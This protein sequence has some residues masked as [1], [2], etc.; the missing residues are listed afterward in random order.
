M[1][2]A[3]PSTVLVKSCLDLLRLRGIFAFRVNTTGVYDTARK[4]FR[5]FQ[6]TKGVSDIVAVVPRTGRIIA[7][8][9]KH[10]TGRLSPDQR[11]FLD[12]VTSA[13]GL[14]LVIRD[15]LDLDRALTAEGIA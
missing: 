6:G 3:N 10:G 1:K 4:V 15:V 5:T 8:E 2:A 9:C 13:G 11:A 14:A 12:N 7:L